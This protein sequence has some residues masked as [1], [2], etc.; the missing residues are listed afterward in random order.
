MPPLSGSR[1]RVVEVCAALD[2]ARTWFKEQ[3]GPRSRRAG[4]SNQ[5]SGEGAAAAL[6]HG[7]D[8]DDHADDG[9]FPGVAR[10]VGAIVRGCCTRLIH[11]AARRLSSSP[12]RSLH[13]ADEERCGGRPL[14]LNRFR[15]AVVSRVPWKLNVRF[16][17]EDLMPLARGGGRERTPT[18]RIPT[19]LARETGGRARRDQRPIPPFRS[20][21]REKILNPSR[22]P[23][24]ET[25]SPHPPSSTLRSP[26]AR[27]RRYVSWFGPSLAPG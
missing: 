15:L 3:E 19:R 9:S 23:R 20:P 18:P 6:K 22:A 13:R 8:V 14:N 16:N 7:C 11:S 2:S 5:V 24:L 25:H 4:R 10:Q 17:D 21:P 1:G 26:R 27:T 12:C